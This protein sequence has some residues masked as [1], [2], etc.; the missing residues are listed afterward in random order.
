[1]SVVELHG[2]GDAANPALADMDR[3][4]AEQ[5]EACVSQGA[6][7]YR[8]RLDNLNR[9]HKVVLKYKDEIETAISEDFSNRSR[10]ESRF[11]ETFVILQAIK[12]CKSNLRKWMKPESRHTG[13]VFMP[14]RSKIHYQPKG[15][16]GIIGPWNYP[17]NLTLGPLTFALAAGNRAMIK[18][19]E[20]TPKASDLLTRM[21][22]EAFDETEVAVITGD[23]EVGQKFS[24]LHFDH[25]I[26]TGST[27]VGRHV[28]RAAAENLVPVTLELGGKS[29]TIL[30]PDTDVK[31][32]AKTLAFGK[33]FNAGQTCIAPDYVL[34]PKG[35]EKEFLDAFSE[36]VKS[37]YPTMKDNQDYSAI[38]N[39]RHFDRISGLVKQAEESGATVTRINPANE[40]M[41]GTRKILPTVVEG[42]GETDGLATEEIFG[43]V[44]PVWGYDSIDDAIDWVNRRDRPLALYIFSDSKATVNKVLDNTT[45]GGA[46]VNDTVLHFAQDDLPFGGI[47]PSGMGAYHGEEGFKTFSH[48]KAVFYQS[49][50]ATTFLLYPPFGWLANFMMNFLTKR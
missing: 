28:M 49:K 23:A 24:S 47:G 16:I 36:T 34:L 13:W 14:G 3:I 45:S 15:V 40:D 25:I 17:M 20:L 31:K 27:A 33:H 46:V 32:A 21:I 41:S 6:P 8:R 37:F 12:Y 10:I 2:S 19:S 38:V 22:K 48:A 42:L 7:D 9:L 43:P 11:A 50:L 44:L 26:F 39:E 29:P 4:L 18:P 1:M 35:K 5:K 30:A